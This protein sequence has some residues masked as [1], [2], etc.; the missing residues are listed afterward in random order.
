M[1]S[2]IYRWTKLSEA[3]TLMKLKPLKKFLYWVSDISESESYANMA[4]RDD[5]YNKW[6]IIEAE[7][8]IPEKYI[9]QISSNEIDTLYDTKNTLYKS[10]IGEYK[11]KSFNIFLIPP[12]F[13]K[14][15]H[16]FKITKIV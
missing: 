6:T 3:I 13:H 9:T 16:N 2:K 5:K 8:S 11:T 4:K 1:K 14:H 7:L 15:L 12:K 10:S